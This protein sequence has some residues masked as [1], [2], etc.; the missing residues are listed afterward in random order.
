MPVTLFQY[1][2]PVSDI[3]TTWTRNPAGGSLYTAIDEFPFDPADNITSP[4]FQFFPGLDW[5]T[6]HGLSTAVDPGYYADGWAVL[7]EGTKSGSAA[8]NL[9]VE[10]KNGATVLANWLISLTNAIQDFTLTLTPTQAA[11]IPSGAY[12]GGWSIALT[13]LAPF[14]SPASFVIVEGVRLRL[15]SVGFE[16]LDVAS[17]SASGLR[18]VGVQSG[19]YLI[20]NA[21]GS[22]LKVV[23][24]SETTGALVMSSGYVKLHA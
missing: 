12:S 11:A 24:G 13:A 21:T 18:S 1:A 23:S 17:G 10:L 15:P 6:E 7:L 14:G 8:N 19:G 22:G 16:H 4:D 3:S 5:P 9:T 2:I 20:A